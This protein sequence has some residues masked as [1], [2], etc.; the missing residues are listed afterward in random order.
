MF[1]KYKGG[2]IYRGLGDALLNTRVVL[3]TGVPV[4]LFKYKGG[5]I[6]RGLGDA[7]LNTRVV[8]KDGLIYTGVP[9]MLFKYKGGLIHRGPGGAP[10]LKYRIL[11][12]G[13]VLLIKPIISS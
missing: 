1:F 10:D 5:L 8:Y 13:S 7:L 9:V 2:L 12:I 11:V 3:Y 6:Y 4:M